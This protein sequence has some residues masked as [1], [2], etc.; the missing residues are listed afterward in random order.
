MS[1]NAGYDSRDLT[2]DI[3]IIVIVSVTRA[4]QNP[5]DLV[6]TEAI[7]E[8]IVEVAVEH[9]KVLTT[10]IVIVEQVS[11]NQE[12]AHKQVYKDLVHVVIKNK[13]IFWKRLDLIKDKVV[14]LKGREKRLLNY[15]HAINLAELVICTPCIN[16]KLAGLN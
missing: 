11:M 2:K 4:T 9:V 5:F 15:R 6:I 10:V 12:H 7:D 3:V 13:S 16:V 14:S 1:R 8:N